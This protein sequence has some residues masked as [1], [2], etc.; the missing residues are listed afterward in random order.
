MTDVEKNSIYL[1]A[2]HSTGA[3]HPLPDFLILHL[4]SRLPVYWDLETAL[5][6]LLIP[7][8]SPTWENPFLLISYNI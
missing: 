3:F 2:G 6:I 8:V 4:Y 1:S 7:D 5:P